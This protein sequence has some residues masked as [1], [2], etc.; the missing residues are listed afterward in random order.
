MMEYLYG[1]G[2]NRKVKLG[3]AFKDTDRDG[4]L[5]M[6]DCAPFD[7]TKHKAKLSMLQKKKLKKLPIYV[8]ER[9]VGLHEG[10][11]H[12]RKWYHITDKKA[13]RKIQKKVYSVLKKFPQIAGKVKR[14]KIRGIVFTSKIKRK[15]YKG[16]GKYGGKI[17]TEHGVASPG[18]AKYHSQTGEKMQGIAIV[19]VSGRRGL[20]Q[21]V[22]TAHIAAH[23][24]QHLK[25]YK[26]HPISGKLYKR[27]TKGKYESRPLERKADEAGY[28]MLKERG[29][30][31]ISKKRR[32]L[33]KKEQ[34]I[35]QMK[36]DKLFKH[37]RKVWAKKKGKKE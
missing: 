8:T 12:P 13:P 29:F 2:K 30:V 22:R 37:Y 34:G 10:D 23:E 9:P 1:T 6:F 24:L 31:A 33:R 20:A 17:V 14:T 27:W 35:T 36:K 5:D 11:P 15:K 32:T 26:Q 18:V 28:K 16:K 21:K 25:Q 3:F 7:P 19:R 4:V